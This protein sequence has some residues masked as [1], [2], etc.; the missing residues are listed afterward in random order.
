M[1]AQGMPIEVV[2]DILGHSSIRMTADVYGHILEP[3]R[4]DAA[5]AMEEAL[6]SL[7]AEESDRRRS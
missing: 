4:A 1:L 6:W 3:Q 7:S 2:S 5:D